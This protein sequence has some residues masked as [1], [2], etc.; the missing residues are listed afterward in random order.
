M[1]IL[2]FGDSVTDMGR[3]RDCTDINKPFGYG[4]GF[5]SFIAA[6]L[7]DEA[8]EKYEVVNRGNGGNRVV[9][10]YARVKADVWNLKPDVLSVLIGI[11]D[12]WHA[13]PNDNGVEPE[14]YEKVYRMLIEDTLKALPDVKIVLCEPFFLEGSETVDSP[15]F[16][17]RYALFC[18]VFDYARIVERLAKEYGLYYLPL[19]KKF[20]EAAKKSA[21]GYYLYDGVHPAPAGAKLIAAEWLKL[22]KEKIV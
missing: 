16:P 10:L 3:D 7:Y 14:R 20:D 2:F 4:Y 12:V 6:E 1:K 5:T 15:E 17:D 19:Q 18:Q 21:P 13:I 8:P 9:D 22:F 11:N